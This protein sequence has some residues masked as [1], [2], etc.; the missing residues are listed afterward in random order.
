M[1]GYQ[2]KVHEVIKKVFWTGPDGYKVHMS[3]QEHK[4]F[5]C[6]LLLNI[7][8]LKPHAKKESSLSIPHTYL[9][10]Q[11][12]KLKVGFGNCYSCIVYEQFWALKSAEKHLC[13]AAG[14]ISYHQRVVC[15]DVPHGR[16]LKT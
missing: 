10:F 2:V 12:E 8:F 3:L 4:L 9:K 1:E 7:H 6:F 16:I 11:P 15:Y 13:I 5:T 14:I